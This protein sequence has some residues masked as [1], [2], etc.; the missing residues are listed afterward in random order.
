[1]KTAALSIGNSNL[2]AALVDGTEVLDKRSVPVRSHDEWPGLI[3]WIRETGCP[4]AAVSVNPLAASALEER[5]P[6]KL[7]LVGRDVPVPIENRTRAPE[8]TG[9]DR[10]LTGFAGAAIFGPPL[11]VVDFGTAF[12][13]NLI[14]DTGAF[15][16]GAIAPGLGLAIQSLA[17]GCAQLPEV[18]RPRGEIPL[19]GL[20]TASA[21]RSGLFNGYLGLVESLVQRLMREAGPDCR[22]VATGGDAAFFASLFSLHEPD[23]LLKGVALAFAGQA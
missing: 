16:G 15:A 5:F 22:A 4:T 7:H 3:D 20:D 10:L 6:D 13:F 14:D 9:H 12:T 17:G 18:E 1:L 23:L 8:Q 11:L 21:I 2:T 19:V